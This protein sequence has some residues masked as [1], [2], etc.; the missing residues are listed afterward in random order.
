[1]ALLIAVCSDWIGSDDSTAC[2]LNEMASIFAE[3]PAI[4]AATIA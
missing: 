4:A 2:L 1:M 3:S